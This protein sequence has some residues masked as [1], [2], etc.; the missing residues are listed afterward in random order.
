[1]GYAV[2]CG[3]L[4]TKMWSN[5]VTF[6]QSNRIKNDNSSRRRICNAFPEDQPPETQNNELLLKDDFSIQKSVIWHSEDVHSCLRAE[7]IRS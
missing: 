5:I 4:W 7:K 6:Q 2:K 3:A 1:M